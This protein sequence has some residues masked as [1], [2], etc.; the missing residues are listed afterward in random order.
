MFL[1][2]AA[3]FKLSSL[4][5]LKKWEIP[6]MPQKYALRTGRKFKNIDE[7]FDSG[8]KRSSH[9]SIKPE[10]NF[11]ELDFEDD[12]EKIQLDQN[13]KAFIDDDD[14]PTTRQTRDPVNIGVLDRLTSKNVGLTEKRSKPSKLPASKSTNSEPRKSK[15]ARKVKN[16]HK[17]SKRVEDRKLRQ[18]K[19]RI[20]YVKS[21]QSA[22]DT[23]K[24][25]NLYVK[26]AAKLPVSKVDF[27][28]SSAGQG[29]NR[30]STADIR[31]LPM[32]KHLRAS[33]LIKVPSKVT[34]D[35]DVHKRSAENDFDGNLMTPKYSQRGINEAVK[36]A[37]IA[38]SNL[39]SRRQNAA[40]PANRFGQLKVSA[41]KVG[42]AQ[43][44]TDLRSGLQQK[45]LQES[46]SQALKLL[47]NSD[48]IKKGPVKSGVLGDQPS[49][50]IINKIKNNSQNRAANQNT[51]KNTKVPSLPQTPSHAIQPTKGVQISQRTKIE[52]PRGEIEKPKDK[53]KIV[54]AN[55]A[56][57]V[58]MAMEQLKRDRMWGKV[59]VHVLPSG[60]LKVMVQ[61]T[62]KMPDD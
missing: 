20:Q 25:N 43:H 47:R 46:R 31:S 7:V 17:N 15:T 60:K 22:V 28:D 24:D 9:W 16:K 30:F 26:A 59:F 61:E 51:A 35:A 4:P 49:K 40:K 19:M 10:L 21:K 54:P 14:I 29:T 27:L 5:Q 39:Q 8:R 6:S 32:S 42:R 37:R 44:G 11:R 23:T 57:A 34:R 58:A 2:R 18:K 62:K 55:V 45:N 48:N 50:T 38:A 12:A 53:M 3:R 13:Y 56:R 1:G 52:S 41:S 36:R 33:K